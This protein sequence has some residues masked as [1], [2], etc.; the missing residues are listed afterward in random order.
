MRVAAARGRGRLDPVVAGALATIISMAGASRPSFWFDEAATISAASRSLEQLTR[1]LG[2]IDAVHGGYY[3]LMHAWFTASPPTEFWSR[4]PSGVAVGL[5]A[6]G[7]V[8]L[9]RQF[10]CRSV[11]MASGITFA[12]LPRVTWA[13]IEARPSALSAMAAVWVTVLLVVAARRGT[14]WLWTA[15]AL[16]M[17]VSMTL[18][19]YLVLMVGVHAAVMWVFRGRRS[20]IHFIAS[21]AIALVIIAPF[22]ALAH[23]QIHQLNWIEPL[24]AHTVIDVGVK[25]YFDRSVPFA[26]L[27]GLIVAAG[28]VLRH[29]GAMTQANGERQLII[30][31]VAW[32]AIPTVS[33]LLYSVTVVPIYYPRYLCFTAPGLAILLG[34]CVVSIAKTPARV[35]AVLALLA[36]AALPNYLYGQRGAYSKYG[37][38]YSRVAD[39]ITRYAAPGDC[40]LLDDTVSWRPGPIRPLVAARPAA[41]RDL[42]DVGLGERATSIDQLWDTNIAPF[43]VADR[44]DRCAVLWTISERDPTV[45]KH[46]VGVAIP[47]GPRFAT[48]NAF[49][50]PR[51]LG[52]RLV[53]RWQ[54]NLAQVIKATR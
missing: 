16:A 24:G 49:W 41:Y 21:I 1:L 43:V 26:I 5:A 34:V 13:G 28:L 25:Q 6:A 10:S 33:T 3:L 48:A 32:M 39:V 46:E 12:L 44:I 30:V 53:E 47:P 4:A 17:V 18:D 35:G 9:S 52:F 22:I 37:M 19:V 14:V 2:N 36:V 51:E 45:P 15:Y 20:S 23:G 40:L 8:M 27:A 31:A 50:V 29:R 38:D 11:A 7:V 42:V 54:F